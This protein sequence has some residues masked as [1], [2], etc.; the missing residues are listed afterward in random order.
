MQELEGK[1]AVVTGAASG[2]GLAL[3][4]RFA[5]DG[6]KVVLADIEGPRLQAA[7]DEVQALGADAIAL[8]TDV[9]DPVQL[10]ALAEAAYAR[11]GAVHVLCNNA[12]VA[13]PGLARPAWE[14]SLADWK[15][16]LDVNLMG[17]VHGLR[18]FVPRMIEGGQPGHVVN[19][20][21]V[22][23]LITGSNPYHVSKHAVTCVTE[24][25][26][27]D[28]RQHAPQLSA[29]VLCPGLINTDIMQAQRNRRPEQGPV[30]DLA[31]LPGTVQAAV[32]Q[33]SQALQAGYDP[34]RVAEAV[35]DAIRAD[36]F[37]V[38]PAQEPLQQVIDLRLGDL[39]QRRNP[40]IPQP[41]KT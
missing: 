39:L 31:S 4:R 17:V 29:S 16:I 34:A 26:Y 35:A 2:I 13:V 23:G 38:I 9:T 5:H 41:L 37:Y 36:R 10:D 14:M 1:V 24:G 18:S 27:K 3:A 32:Q 19:T 20:A 8:Q 25:L 30:L 15:W 7:L 22:A 11:F 28:F 6:L 21:S 33:F 40:T 12:G